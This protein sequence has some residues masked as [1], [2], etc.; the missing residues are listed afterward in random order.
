MAK[1][2]IKE[3]LREHGMTE[4]GLAKDLGV[5]VQ[6]INGICN[7]RLTFKHER[8]VALADRIGCKWTDL[9]TE[10]Y[11]KEL[12]DRLRIKDVKAV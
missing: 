6:Y 8:L 1:L 9:V 12:K 11:V 10:E 3:Y 2:R 7:E 4:L 5:S